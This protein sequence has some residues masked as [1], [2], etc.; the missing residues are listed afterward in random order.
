MAQ[1]LV[2][3]VDVTK[4]DG[5]RACMVA[6]KNWNDLP[7]DIE[8]FSGYASH[9]ELSD[10]TWNNITYKEVENTTRNEGLDWL[11]AHKSCL[12]CVDAACE[13]VCP[14][15]A[16]SHSE[17]GS[18]V[19]DP[20]KCVACG[21]C[22]TNCTFDV[23]RLGTIKDQNGHD[24]KVSRKCTLCTDRLDNGLDPACVTACHTGSLTI[25]PRAEMLK[26][27]EERLAVVKERYPSANIYNP[28]GL[29]GT[30]MVFLL[31][32]KPA[33]YD[34]PANPELTLS[35]IVWKDYAQ[36]LG[37]M[38]LGATTMAVA[39]AIVTNKI[40]NKKEKADG[41]EDHEQ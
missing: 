30:A 27:A 21:Y 8:G 41:G 19:L 16:L 31:A 18:V 2:K 29:N 4:C 23:I 9:T 26:I 11:F 24:K 1:E 37:K 28:E 15:N 20:E 17:W 35:Q 5:C 22:V 32:N 36:P 39:T 14:E 40:F 10:V 12:H 25:G 3:F 6:C 7:A 34:L 33:V 13:K 38:M